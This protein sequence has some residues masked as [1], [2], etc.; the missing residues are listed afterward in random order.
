MLLTTYTIDTVGYRF[1][2]VQYSTIVTEEKHEM[3][4]NL[5]RT[6]HISTSRASYGGIF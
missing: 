4:L 6:S 5:Q 2:A 1:N 3:T